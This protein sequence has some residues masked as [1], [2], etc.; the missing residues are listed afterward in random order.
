MK[1]ESEVMQDAE[2]DLWL[3][4]AIEENGE[5][6]QT[7]S[8]LHQKILNA[9][10]QFWTYIWHHWDLCVDILRMNLKQAA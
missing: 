8:E 7:Y 5:S 6:L 9:P 4:V 10:D 2:G 3:R 1:I